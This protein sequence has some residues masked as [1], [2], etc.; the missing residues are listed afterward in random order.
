[1]TVLVLFANNNSI[2]FAGDLTET[3]EDGKTYD[4]IRKTF[5][6][7]NDL[8]AGVMFNGKV[9]FEDLSMETLIG[10]FKKNVDFKELG[11]IENIKNEFIN[12]ISK[13]TKYTSVNKYLEEVIER[14]K[15]ELTFKISKSSFEKVIESKK[16]EKIYSYV[17]EYEN[18]E[19]EFFDIIPNGKDKK[20][21]NQIIWEIFCHD[22]YFEG[23]G[24]IF[25]GFDMT[26]NHP[27][28]FEINL[29]CNDNGNIIY[30]EIASKVNFK[31]PL[32]RVFAMN[33]EAYTFI[34]GV[35][36]KF[37]NHMVEYVEDSNKRIIN[38]IRFFLE[39]NNVKNIR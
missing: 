35:N 38:N 1:M 21:Y 16:R 31:K 14:F 33:E 26:H 37:Q 20:R 15:E 7:T 28:Y 24:V 23:T 39:N 4:G 22:L 8:P 10:L 13:I 9:D 25:G 2:I 19:Y 17:K 5:E 3:M 32:I 6:L 34:T 30:D 36:Y 27:S 18:F 11:S 12:F 29:H